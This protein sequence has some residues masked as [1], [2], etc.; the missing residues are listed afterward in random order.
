MKNATTPSRGLSGSEAYSDQL[1]LGGRW[2]PVTSCVVFVNAPV[3]RAVD[4]LV[5]G[6]RGAKV[7]ELYGSPLRARSVSAGS[8]EEMLG[9]LVPLD[10]IEARRTLLLPTRHPEWTAYFDSRS[11]GLDP[12]SPLLWYVAAGVQSLAVTDVPHSYQEDTHAGFYG[13]R[14][15]EMFETQDDGRAIG[16]TLGVR[17]VSARKWEVIEPD[18][19][20]PVGNVWTSTARRIPDR[21][22][23]DDLVEMTSRF[24]LTPFDEDFYAP[25]GTG[26]IIERTD[27]PGTSHHTMTLRQA[28]R[29]ESL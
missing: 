5:R 16:H 28:R 7:R 1:L 15:I 2:L 27:A 23:H 9:N 18:S 19:E 8:L 26:V 24:D 17:T 4:V 25:A 6:P 22:T 11:H 20:F 10:A 3:D 14:K 21:F 12:V 29:E 13:I